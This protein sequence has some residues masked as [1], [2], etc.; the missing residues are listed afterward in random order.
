VR[1]E[2]TT[3]GG[4]ATICT[5]AE[6]MKGDKMGEACGTSGKRGQV[7]IGLWQGNMKETAHLK[8]K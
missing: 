4:A 8:R 6:Q 5:A 3:Y 1:L 2:K 7:H